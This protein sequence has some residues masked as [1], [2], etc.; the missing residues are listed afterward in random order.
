M[1]RAADRANERGQQRTERR[2]GGGALCAVCGSGR[3]GAVVCGAGRPDARVPLIPYGRIHP[4]RVDGSTPVVPVRTGMLLA[5]AP[6]RESLHF[7]KLQTKIRLHSAAAVLRNQEVG[8]M[9]VAPAEN[10]LAKAFAAF[11]IDLTRRDIPRSEFIALLTRPGGAA[12]LST[13]DAEALADLFGDSSVFDVSAFVQQ[14]RSMTGAKAEG[15][16]QPDAVL[17][18][19]DYEHNVQTKSDTTQDALPAA[20]KLLHAR[21]S[22]VTFVSSGHDAALSDFNAFMDAFSSAARRAGSEEA[23]FRASFGEDRELLLTE[24]AVRFWRAAATKFDTPTASLYYVRLAC[25][26]FRAAGIASGADKSAF[27]KRF[28]QEMAA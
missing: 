23:S 17:S 24:A 12:P 11:S 10:A 4:K 15:S 25:A 18:K 28:L 9:G 27:E 8:N 20:A 3:V 2:S 26:A 5:G 7:Y 1:L 14:C 16:P 13:A 21:I 19:R 22:E 6:T